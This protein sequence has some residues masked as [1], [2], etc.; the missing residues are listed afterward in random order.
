VLIGDDSLSGEEAAIGYRSRERVE[1]AFRSIKSFVELRP[2]H[3]HLPARIRA[4]V[5]VCVL[6]YLVERLVEL[7]AER[8]WRSARNDT[9]TAL[10]AVTWQ[11]GSGLVTQTRELRPEERVI[12]EKLK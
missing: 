12:F 1:A 11:A 8:S 9:L 2:I 6:A 5:L 4:H 7:R 3:H 10:T